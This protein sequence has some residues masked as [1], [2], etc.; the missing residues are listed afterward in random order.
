[1]VWR[2]ILKV[3]SPYFCS[4]QNHYDN[5]QK[6]TYV[7]SEALD[8]EAQFVTLVACLIQTLHT[9]PLTSCH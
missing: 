4:T 8:L 2:C 3:E 9:E 6:T 5:H 7:S 1:M